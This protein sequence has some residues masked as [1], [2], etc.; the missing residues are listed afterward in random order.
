M[1][2]SKNDEFIVLDNGR[3]ACVIT[4]YEYFDE[5]KRNV[6]RVRLLCRVKDSLTRGKWFT[7]EQFARMIL[8]G[9]WHIRHTGGYIVDHTALK[10]DYPELLLIFRRDRLSVRYGRN[11]T[12]FYE[13]WPHST[14]DCDADCET[15]K[16]PTFSEGIPNILRMCPSRKDSV[17]D[18]HVPNEKNWRIDPARPGYPVPSR[19][20]QPE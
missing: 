10:D 8:S 19:L 3:R 14:L 13:R 5:G 15:C 1:S 18:E 2:Y 16:A 7:L 17:I 12:M 9:K 20:L 11:E 6:S 4:G